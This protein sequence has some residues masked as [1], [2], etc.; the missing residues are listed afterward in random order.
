MPSESTEIRDNYGTPAGASDEWAAPP[1]VFGAASALWGPFMLDAAAA[2]WNSKCVLFFDKEADG[3]AHGWSGRVWLNPPY[4]RGQLELWMG[5]ARAEVLEGRADL[6]CCLVPG[7]TAE[8][9]WHRHVEAPAGESVGAGVEVS[10]LGPRTQ[11]RYQH[12]TIETLR[13]RGR[14]RFVEE[15]GATGPARFPSVLVVLARPEVLAPL[16]PIRKVKRGPKVKFCT[17]DVQ[18]VEALLAKG[19]V[20]ARACQLAG[21]ARSTWYRHEGRASHG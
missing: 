1:E 6:V 3:L 11:A 4:S 5:K 8:G 14:V 20:V 9:W 18:A 21:V 15:S 2:P 10:T 17:E 12:L 16:R 7:H 19:H 13:I